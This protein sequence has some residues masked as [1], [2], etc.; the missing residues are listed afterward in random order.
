MVEI[1]LSKA[2][3]V[4]VAE[5]GTLVRVKVLISNSILLVRGEDRHNVSW[6]K[7]SNELIRARSQRVTRLRRHKIFNQE[8]SVAIVL[9]ELSRSQHRV[10]L[11]RV[12]FCAMTFSG[13]SA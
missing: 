4:V 7:L 13:I 8:K 9:I 10:S 12:V 1:H 3:L 11:P 6:I 5:H 2:K